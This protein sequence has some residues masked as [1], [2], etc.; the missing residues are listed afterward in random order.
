MYSLATKRTPRIKALRHDC[1]YRRDPSDSWDYFTLI[2]YPLGTRNNA[3]F[4]RVL[5]PSGYPLSLGRDL[6][7]STGV[8]RRQIPATDECAAGQL[9]LLDM[10]TAVHK[11][12]YLLWVPK[13]LMDIPLA[14]GLHVMR[15]AIQRERTPEGQVQRP[16]DE[17]QEFQ[18]HELVAREGFKDPGPLKVIL[19]QDIEGKLH[20]DL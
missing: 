4:G 3:L 8:F 18:M 20:E 6:G 1:E 13:Y 14:V 9:K 11:M 7:S 15:H 10:L 5:V 17:K 2:G 12:R 16:P 19:L